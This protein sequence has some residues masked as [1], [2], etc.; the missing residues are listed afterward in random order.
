VIIKNKNV[1]FT[2]PVDVVDKLREYVNDEY[3]SSLNAGV[4]EALSEYIKKLDQLKLKKE[5]EKAAKD[6]IFLKDI[7]DTMALF[8]KSDSES[9]GRTQEW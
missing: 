9:A 2:L 5:M 6:D 1:T 4:R 3:I 8:E 7:T